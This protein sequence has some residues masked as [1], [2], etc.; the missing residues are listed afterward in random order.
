MYKNA[1]AQH[2]LSNL[3]MSI[4]MFL[5]LSADCNLWNDSHNLPA[6]K[7]VIVLYPIIYTLPRI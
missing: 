3:E 6:W 5:S 7:N 4:K 1:N 2:C